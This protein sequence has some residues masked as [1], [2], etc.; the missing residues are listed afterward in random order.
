MAAVGAVVC[1]SGDLSLTIDAKRVPW[2]EQENLKI[3]GLIASARHRVVIRCD[4]KP[5]QS[6]TFRFSELK[7]TDLCLFLNDLYR[8]PQ[9]A[10]AKSSPWCKCR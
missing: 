9:L 1:K 5:Q 3:D 2:S 7:S 4:N 6:F 10:P 8:T